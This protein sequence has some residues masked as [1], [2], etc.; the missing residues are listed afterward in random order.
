MTEN[1]SVRWSRRGFIRSGIIGSIATSGCLSE[2]NPLSNNTPT[3]EPAPASHPTGDENWPQFRYDS[4]N[5]GFHP[6]AKAPRENVD[7]LWKLTV[8]RSF[9]LLS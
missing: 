3:P 5:S 6:S 9:A 4:R 7:L 2:E 8:D 1:D